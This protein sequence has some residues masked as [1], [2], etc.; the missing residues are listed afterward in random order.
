MRAIMSQRRTARHRNTAA[1]RPTTA[2][3]ECLRDLYAELD[4]ALTAWGEVEVAPLRHYIAYRGLVNV[5]SVIFRPKH[6]VTDGKG[7]LTAPH[8]HGEVELTRQK[9]AVWYAGG[10]RTAAAHLAGAAATSD[11][12]LTKLIRATTDHEPWLPD[13]F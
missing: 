5:A 11:E 6:E 8:R 7:H 10:F 4:D 9:L 12:A 13:H 3:P 1:P 2:A